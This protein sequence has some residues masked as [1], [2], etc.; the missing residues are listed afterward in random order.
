MV[1]SALCG[2][3]GSVVMVTLA[4]HFLVWM[5]IAVAFKHS[6]YFVCFS[7]VLRGNDGRCTK[8]WH[9]LFLPFILIEC[10]HTDGSGGGRGGDGGGGGGFQV[11]LEKNI[12][13]KL[14]IKT[15]LLFV[16]YIIITI[17]F[18]M[19]Q[20][21][22]THS[23]SFLYPLWCCCRQEVSV[24]WNAFIGP[25]ITVSPSP[26]CWRG[27]WHPCL[28]HYRLRGS[29]GEIKDSCSLLSNS[30]RQGDAADPGSVY[31]WQRATKM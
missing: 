18:G 3:A 16:L 20:R 23:G 11:Y 15:E 9:A 25:S 10:R 6:P 19:I 13:W 28:A 24:A 26:L 1:W 17:L 14:W 31:F 29:R 4:H 22:T 30:D 5:L 8:A 7:E 12:P 27:D 2:S 21:C